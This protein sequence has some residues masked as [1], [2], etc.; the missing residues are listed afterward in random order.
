MLGRP[1]ASP[2]ADGIPPLW[3]AFVASAHA[4]SEGDTPLRRQL[5]QFYEQRG[6]RP[7]WVRGGRLTPDARAVVQALQ[8]AGTHGLPADRYVGVPRVQLVTEG[9]ATLDATELSI[10]SGLLSY[11]RDVSMGRL[12][13]R[14]V[15]TSW[16]Q[17]PETVDWAGAI[18]AAA[19]AGRVAEL[20]ASLPP[21]H[22]QYAALRRGLERYRDIAARGGWSPLVVPAR[23]RADQRGPA[24]AALRARLA[25]EGYEGGDKGLRAFQ[26]AHGLAADGVVDA[27]TLAALDV[28][29]AARIA[30]IELGLER[31]RWVPRDLGERH[32][33]VNVPAFELH[34]IADGRE[35]LA[36]RVVTGK[37]DNPT[38]VFSE[39]MTGIVFSPWWNVPQSI[40]ENEILP[41]MKRRP[42]YL[43]HAGLQTVDGA[44]RQPPGPNNALGLVKFVLPD[45]FHVYLHDTPADALFARASRAFSHGC[46]R[47]EKPFELAQW[48]LAGQPQWTA[49][50]IRAAMG[51][52]REQLVPLTATIPV[53][54]VYM[55]AWAAADGAVSFYP[56]VYGHDLEQAP[57]LAP[58]DSL[59]ARAAGGERAG[60]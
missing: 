6:W 34:A 54:I 10:T 29:V 33:I 13:P 7:A 38:P 49:A 5:Q 32:V 1:T 27:R 41:A 35:Q 23:T 8:A 45:P 40:V 16:A 48:A 56:D 57:R 2:A 26:R 11:A 52:R 17:Q 60:R 46:V 21:T 31:W 3:D 19:D 15:S 37:P 25:A 53:H 22:A 18:G 55:T 4:S 59:E 24:G 20:L 51:S 58:A 9:T 43:Q 39:E 30:Q 28:P 12:E 50:R 36:M 47:V 42:G 44:F 14:R